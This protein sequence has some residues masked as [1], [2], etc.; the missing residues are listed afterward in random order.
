MND[1]AGQTQPTIFTIG[2]SNQP[3]EAFIELLRANSVEVVADVRSSPY[4]QYATQFNAEQ[5]KA[6]IIAAGIKYVFMGHEL[7]GKP[8]G[9]EFYD[10]AGYVLYWRLAQSPAFLAGIARLLKGIR[11][12]RTAIMCSEENPAECHRRLLIGRVL[13]ERGVTV[14][15]VRHDGAAQSEAD[16]V[17]EEEAAKPNSGQLSLFEIEDKPEWKSTR[18]VSPA[19]QPPNSSEP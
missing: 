1:A 4:S 17:R 12:Y 2:H 10:G 8:A 15:H 13:A 11:N 9:S 18:S 6:A 3:I 14:L 19:K 7:G 5:V 16:I